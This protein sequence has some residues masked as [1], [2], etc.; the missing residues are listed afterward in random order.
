MTRLESWSSPS[1]TISSVSI[2]WNDTADGTPH[3]SVNV[4]HHKPALDGVMQSQISR[5]CA[6][7]RRYEAFGIESEFSVSAGASFLCHGVP[8]SPDKGSTTCNKL[9][10]AKALRLSERIY[11]VF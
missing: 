4:F 1:F 5:Q 6:G 8:I 3:P 2:C 10:H 7:S 11:D 9:E